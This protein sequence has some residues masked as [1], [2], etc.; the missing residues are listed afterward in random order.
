MTSPSRRDHCCRMDL[1]FLLSQQFYSSWT[2]DEKQSDHAR[3]RFQSLSRR[4]YHS[5]QNH[6]VVVLLSA[7]RTFQ[8]NGTTLSIAEHGEVAYSMSEM[9]PNIQKG[10][11]IELLELTSSSDHF[12]A[13]VGSFRRMGRS[14]S[15]SS[16]WNNAI[17]AKAPWLSPFF[18]AGAAADWL[19]FW[20]GGGR[21]GP[22]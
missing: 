18:L 6:P 4:R 9:D 5:G 15:C 2:D 21:L 3:V 13:L 14:S 17:F 11:D 19:R 16:E 20:M 7:K 12:P 22:G 10:W 1:P 8:M